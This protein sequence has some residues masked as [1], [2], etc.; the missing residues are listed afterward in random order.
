MGL[1]MLG[2]E[3][4]R[5]I[6]ETCRRLYPNLL[7]YFGNQLGI[8]DKDIPLNYSVGATQKTVAARERRAGRR[9]KLLN[10]RR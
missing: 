10:C 8:N 9:P 7:P 6:V 4:R 5:K 1:M 3:Q 2:E